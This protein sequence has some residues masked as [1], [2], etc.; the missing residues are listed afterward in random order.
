M[1]EWRRVCHIAGGY[2][3]VAAAFVVFAMAN[4]GIVVGDRDAHAPVL[5]AAQLPYGLLFSV[6]AFLPLCL[7]ESA[8]AAPSPPRAC[9]CPA[10]CALRPSTAPRR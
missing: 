8:C 1:Q 10:G 6:A 5:H 7:A 4:G 2:A 3:A 9:C